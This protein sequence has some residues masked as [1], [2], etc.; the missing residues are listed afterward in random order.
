M[1]KRKFIST[2][3]KK[4]VVRG[5]VDTKTGTKFSLQFKQAV[6]D[7]IWKWHKVSLYEDKP[8]INDEVIKLLFHTTQ[9]KREGAKDC[10]SFA[11]NRHQA[12]EALYNGYSLVD[13]VNNH[14]TYRGGKIYRNGNCLVDI[15]DDTLYV[16]DPF[17]APSLKEESKEQKVVVEQPKLETRRK[18]ALSEEMLKALN[19]S[20]RPKRRAKERKKENEELYTSSR[21]QSNQK[22]VGNENAKDF[23]FGSLFGL[24][25]GIAGSLLFKFIDLNDNNYYHY[26]YNKGKRA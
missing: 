17:I 5:L 8:L 12:L 18:D 1:I 4:T 15:P 7:G 11:I 9:Q 23:L 24:G 6:D 20:T 13:E 26:Y 19:Q 16:R 25:L 3:G 22:P 21:N 10:Y 14:Y 2:F